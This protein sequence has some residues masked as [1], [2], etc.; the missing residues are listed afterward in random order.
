M[1]ISA[2]VIIRKET[3]VNFQTSGCK[4]LCTFLKFVGENVSDIVTQ[5]HLPYLP[6]HTLGGATQIDYFYWP[7]QVRKPI[8][9]ALSH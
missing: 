6:R 1:K 4:G 5:Y 2:K 7:R 9:L 3:V 8:S